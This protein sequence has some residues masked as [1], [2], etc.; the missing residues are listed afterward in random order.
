MGDA[1]RAAGAVSGMGVA[2]ILGVVAWRIGTDTRL[3]WFVVGGLMLCV[4]LTL[5]IIAIRQTREMWVTRTAMLRVQ[6]ESSLISMRSVA[7][8]KDAGGMRQPDP[9]T[10]LLA[11]MP[12]QDVIDGVGHPVD[13]DAGAHHGGGE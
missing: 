9:W 2:G 11:A 12:Q 3:T 10:S 5:V 7:L 1:W 8:V 4:I 6:N 13:Y